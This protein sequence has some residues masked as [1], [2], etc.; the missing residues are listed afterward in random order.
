MRQWNSA[1]K[2]TEL[3]FDIVDIKHTAILVTINAERAIATVW[4]WNLTDKL[5]TITEWDIHVI[6]RNA[7]EQLINI[8]VNIHQIWCDPNLWKY[9]Q[10]KQSNIVD[11]AMEQTRYDE[12]IQTRI[13]PD[14]WHALRMKVVG[15]IKL[16]MGTHQVR[17]PVN[18][19]VL[20]AII[21]GTTE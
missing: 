11:I 15:I 17:I 2:I 4:Q 1:N 19:N 3:G 10:P 21:F 12:T 20:S 5:P 14:Q 6:A 16:L 7:N 18:F 9:C 8:D 13:P